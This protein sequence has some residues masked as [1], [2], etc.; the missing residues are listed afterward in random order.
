MSNTEAPQPGSTGAPQPGNTEAPQPGWPPAGGGT[1]GA[2][3]VGGAGGYGYYGV[4]AI[5]AAEEAV[6][7]GTPLSWRSRWGDRDH[8][9]RAG[10]A[11]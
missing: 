6:G 10:N 5:P 1:A 11:S 4:P 9:G 3:Q 2:G 7:S 8:S